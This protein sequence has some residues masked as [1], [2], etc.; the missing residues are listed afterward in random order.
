[1]SHPRVIRRDRTEKGRLKIEKTE[2]SG[3][4]KETGRVSISN[5]PSAE[6]KVGSILNSDR[7]ILRKSNVRRNESED[8]L[9]A[10]ERSTALSILDE[11]LRDDSRSPA[12]EGRESRKHGELIL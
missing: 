1:M 10:L 5:S 4:R 7:E 2:I 11:G 3:R 8:V 12:E 6:S 9:G